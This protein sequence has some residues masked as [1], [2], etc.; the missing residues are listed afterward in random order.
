MWSKYPL[1]MMNEIP[2]VAHFQVSHY[3][4]SLA[5][6]DA[7]HEI[8]KHDLYCKI[9]ASRGMLNAFQMGRIYRQA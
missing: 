7:L 8:C 2:L 4:L 1:T 6:Q 3:I 5:A 9:G